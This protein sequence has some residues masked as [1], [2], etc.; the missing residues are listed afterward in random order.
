MSNAK[1]YK[2]N[3]VKVPNDQTKIS[4]SSFAG[5]LIDPGSWYKSQILH[6]STF[7]GNSKT[8]LGTCLHVRAYLSL[9]NIPFQ[10][11]DE[12]NYI[13]SFKFTDDDLAY[14]TDNIEPMWNAFY[15][16][17]LDR[18]PKPLLTEDV[19]IKP[20]ANA[21][22][23]IAGSVD[24][25]TSHK[26]STGDGIDG[27]MFVVDYKS[28][29]KKPS[30]MN[31]SHFIQAL[32]YAYAYKERGIDIDAI[33]IV[34]ITKPTKT[35]PARVFVFERKIDQFNF[36]WIEH[37][38]N[39]AAK[40]LELVK[41]EPALQDVIFTPNPT[42]YYQDDPENVYSRKEPSNITFTSLNDIV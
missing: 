14:I 26:L 13:N 1:H 11:K 42:S 7:T 25:V 24:A 31:D 39:I 12:D 20:I 17:Y 28:V 16:D 18:E 8:V 30:G 6:E 9:N 36:N 21:H 23:T 33:R 22:T 40:K 10:K 19:I 34:Y 29:E 27:N 41:A 38:V 15:S 2:Y 5:L 3:N 32:T 4:P 37:Q 35:L